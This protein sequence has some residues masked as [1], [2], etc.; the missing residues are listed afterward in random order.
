MPDHIMLVFDDKLWNGKDVGD[1]SQFWKRARILSYHGH[2]ADRVATVRFEHDGRLSGGH[3][4]N[5]MK[6]DNNGD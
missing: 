5:A 3:F 4:I 6:V 2:G 1:N